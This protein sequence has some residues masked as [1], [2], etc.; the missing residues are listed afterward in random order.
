MIG[1][2]QQVRSESGS[3][4]ED[5][6]ADP[7]A[8]CREQAEKPRNERLFIAVPLPRELLDFVQRAQKALPVSGNLRLLRPEQLHI[9]LAFLGHVGPEKAATARDIVLSAPRDAGGMAAIT[10]FLMLPS[11][12]RA[13]V[14]SLALSDRDGVLG[15][16]FENIMSGLEAAGVMQREK[17]PFRP[18]VTIARLRTPGPVQP[19]YE[20]G[21]APYAVESVCLYR[22]E[23]KRGGAE[24]TV[25]AR[26]DLARQSGTTS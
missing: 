17:R 8:D 13:R 5:A 26:A 11:A 9:T 18:H 1:R 20:S 3:Q 10:G 7:S 4:V 12:K 15:G 6:C 23:L 14:V 25:V 19:M 2:Q 22:S 24:Y 16:L 21:T